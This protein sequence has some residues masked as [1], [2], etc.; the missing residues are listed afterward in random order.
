[1]IS[2]GVVKKK[3]KHHRITEILIGFS[4]ALNAAEAQELSNYRLVRSGRHGS[5]T[6]KNAR[7]L[8]LK[9]AM[10]DAA[11]D[12]V[13][14]IPRKRLLVRKTYQLVVEGQ[15][16]SGLQDSLGRYIDGGHKGT[17]GSNA[18]AVLSRGWAT[19]K[20]IASGATGGQAFGIAA[21]VNRLLEAGDLVAATRAQ[22]ARREAR[23]VAPKGDL[24][25]QTGGRADPPAVDRLLQEPD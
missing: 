5:F 4:G 14:L 24:G 13:T 19:I 23:Y 16:P 21:V 20:A 2:A 9:S 17:A 1:M 6:A 7:V 12:L 10:Y 18:V 15:P 25:R 3:V 11:G 8:K 22:R